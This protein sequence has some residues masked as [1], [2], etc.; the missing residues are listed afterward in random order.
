MISSLLKVPEH[1][2][3]LATEKAAQ[4]AG[5]AQKKQ[6]P[7]S[8]DDGPHSLKFYLSRLTLISSRISVA[9]FICLVIFLWESSKEFLILSNCVAIKQQPKDV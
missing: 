9:C 8:F 1:S 5:N 2:K 7:L 4:L 6:I 3:S